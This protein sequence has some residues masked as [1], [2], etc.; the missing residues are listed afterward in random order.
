MDKLQIKLGWNVYTALVVL[1]LVVAAKSIEQYNSIKEESSHNDITGYTLTASSTPA[2]GTRSIRTPTCNKLDDRQKLQQAYGKHV[3]QQGFDSTFDFDNNDIVN[4]ADVDAIRDY[5]TSQCTSQ[6]TAALQYALAHPSAPPVLNPIVPQTA[7]VGQELAITLSASDPDGD[8]LEFEYMS[9][10]AMSELERVDDVIPSTG[11]TTAVYRVTPT[12]PGE[13]AIWF[14]ATDGVNGDYEYVTITVTSPPQPGTVSPPAATAPPQPATTSPPAATAPESSEEVTIP[15]GETP[16]P[17]GSIGSLLF[18]LRP[19]G[20]DFPLIFEGWSLGDLSDPVLDSSLDANVDAYIG[21]KPLKPGSS[22]SYTA[23]IDLRPSAKSEN[24]VFEYDRMAGTVSS[25]VYNF[26]PFPTQAKPTDHFYK[27]SIQFSPPVPRAELVGSVLRVFN[28]NLLVLPSSDITNNIEVIEKSPTDPGLITVGDQFSYLDI[29]SDRYWIQASVSSYASVGITVRKGPAGSAF[30]DSSLHS[31]GIHSS[32]RYLN[33]NELQQIG[34]LI[35]GVAERNYV[36]NIENSNAKL[37]VLKTSLDNRF[38]IT[39]TVPLVPQ[40]PVVLTDIAKVQSQSQAVTHNIVGVEPFKVNLG[41]SSY[42]IISQVISSYTFIQIRKAPLNAPFS[43]SEGGG[44]DYINVNELKQ[45]GDLV[46]GVLSR[47]YIPGNIE[48]SSAQLV[49]FRGT[50]AQ[51]LS[52]TPPA[53]PP[54]A[55]I[56]YY[57]D[58]SMNAGNLDK[59]TVYV[60]GDLENKYSLK[61]GDQFIDPFWRT[62]RF[63]FMPPGL[64]PAVSLVDIRSNP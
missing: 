48:G 19:V 27:T 23:A 11:P 7:V 55:Q 36:G 40:A 57:T 8:M 26:G 60:A 37:V 1:L 54:E 64:Y 52:V 12:T 2:G 4:D 15:V 17:A 33:V 5:F 47:N 58:F 9:N 18:Q 41:D 42:Y 44:S 43:S 20:E 59:I 21:T 24:F 31:G 29:G 3:G 61:Q 45:M 10:F 39:K 62:F 30:A 28:K 63:S 46:V 22:Y 38:S 53:A 35:I 56:P 25:P 16:E 34:D 49:L 14:I 32:M 13:Y 50:L 51:A 6:V